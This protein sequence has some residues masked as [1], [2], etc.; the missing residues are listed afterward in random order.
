MSRYC[1]YTLLKTLPPCWELRGLKE[2]EGEKRK[3]TRGG[4]QSN[5]E[6]IFRRVHLLARVIIDCFFSLILTNY[7]IKEALSLCVYICEFVRA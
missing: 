2:K 4:F 7:T 6:R 3:S 5:C 1:A